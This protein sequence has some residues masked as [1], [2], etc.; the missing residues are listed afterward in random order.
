VASLPKGTE[1]IALG[2]PK[3]NSYRNKDGV[4]V[5]RLEWVLDDIAASVQHATLQ[6]S[7]IKHNL[8]SFKPNHAQEP[9]YSD[10]ED[11]WASY[12]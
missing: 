3:P 10:T 4:Q 8:N 1:V 12:E 2:R 5:T 9:R 6:V 7:R 11:Q